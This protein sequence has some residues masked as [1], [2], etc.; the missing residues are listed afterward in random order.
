[1]SMIVT[2][3]LT[4]KF[5]AFKAV[6]GLNLRIAQGESYGFLGPNG[7][8]K[9]TTLSML[10]GILTPTSGMVFIQ[11]E[12]VRS[13]SFSLKRKIGVVAE[14]QTFYENMTAWE[15]VMF[16]ARLYQAAN[17][18][19][20]AEMLFEQV[21]LMQWKDALISAFSTGMKK[22]LGFIRALVH[23]PDLLILD[24]P[25]SGLDPFGIIQVRSLLMTEK[26]RGAT[27]IISSHILSEVEKTTDRVGII[28]R[29]KLILE[30]TIDNIQRKVGDGERILFRFANQTPDILGKLSSLP[31][32]IQV[33]QEED[34]ISVLTDGAKDYRE[35]LGRYLVQNEW[36][37]LEMK[38]HQT[39]LEEVYITI[40]E[41][42]LR[43]IQEDLETEDVPSD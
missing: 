4:K 9:T 19:K 2:S 35:D 13:D 6:D 27:L 8:G 12:Q 20:R 28:S 43:T 5:G 32:V 11:G 33:S 42:S 41:Q 37:P 16:F 24:E 39:S 31:F 30:D 10:L 26:A 40:S 22:K 29:G 36:I 1:M 17:A 34:E 25:V 23:S 14:Y 7:A 18:E 15:Y 38:K 21:N 3:D